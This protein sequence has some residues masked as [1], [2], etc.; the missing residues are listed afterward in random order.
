MKGLGLRFLLSTIAQMSPAAH[1]VTEMVART[2]MMTAGQTPTI[3]SRTSLL[4][5]GTVTGMDLVMSGPE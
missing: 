5:G 2:W 3:Y 4:N 1:G